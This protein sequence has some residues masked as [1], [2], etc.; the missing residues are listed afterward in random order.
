MWYVYLI[1]SVS[2]PDQQ[3][4]QATSDL[5]R[6]LAA[7][8]ADK[9]SRTANHVPWQVLWHCAFPARLAA[10]AFETYLKSCSG[11]VF[12]KKRLLCRLPLTTADHNHLC[13]AP[14]DAEAA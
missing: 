7:H 8:D 13:A 4:I 2:A 5:R 3:H 9:S 6:C 12:A 1:R 10:L 14:T 11:R